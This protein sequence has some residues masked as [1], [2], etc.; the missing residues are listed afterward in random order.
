MENRLKIDLKAF[1]S[2]KSRDDH[3]KFIRIYDKRDH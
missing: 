1:F 3:V 2:M